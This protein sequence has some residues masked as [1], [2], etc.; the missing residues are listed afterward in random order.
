[1]VAVRGAGR[2]GLLLTHLS[3][4]LLEPVLPPLTV[5]GR[6]AVLL[7]CNG[8]FQLSGSSSDTIFIIVVLNCSSPAPGTS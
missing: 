7:G 6:G 5:V 3:K 1:M 2:S 8:N 4:A